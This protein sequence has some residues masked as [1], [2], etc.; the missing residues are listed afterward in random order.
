M[1]LKP[2]IGAGAKSVVYS[3]ESYGSLSYDGASPVENVSDPQSGRALWYV[4][5][6]GGGTTLRV[7]SY[8]FASCAV[9]GIV[10]KRQIVVGV[11]IQL[12][13]ANCIPYIMY[14]V[15]TVM[16]SLWWSDEAEMLS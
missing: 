15:I 4:D 9:N 12:L 14:V 1:N 6:L 11:A 3:D 7:P 5:Y 8:L 13:W 10:A 2:A 16:L